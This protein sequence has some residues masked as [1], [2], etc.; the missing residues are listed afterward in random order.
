[1]STAQMKEAL[2]NQLN[3]FSRREGAKVTLRYAEI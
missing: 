1:M 3:Y 2:I